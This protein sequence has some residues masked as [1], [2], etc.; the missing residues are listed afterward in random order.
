MFGRKRIS[1]TTRSLTVDGDVVEI[2]C[3]D[4][5]NVNLRVRRS[6]GCLVVSA[7]YGVRDAVIE[8]FVR[9]KQDWIRRQRQRPRVGSGEG[10]IH[11]PDELNKKRMEIKVETE[12]LLALWE[13][14]IGVRVEK[15]AYRDMTSRWGSCNPTTG[16]VCIN[17]QLAF[18]PAECLEYVVVHELCHFH[19][20]GHGPSFKN[21]LDK[22]LPDWRERRALLR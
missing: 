19:E 8:S 17:I 6:D 10:S 12:K 1:K 22:Y 11:D 4:I 7:P 16:R 21:L 13:P 15:L 3:K 5:K 2:T 18:Y 20:R 9:T 14:A